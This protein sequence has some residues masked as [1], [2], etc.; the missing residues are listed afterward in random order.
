MKI[1]KQMGETLKLAVLTAIVVAAMPDL[2]MAAGSNDVNN[3][4]QNFSKNQ[5]AG[6]PVILNAA[7]YVGGL[8][9]MVTGAL[10]LKSHTVNPTS[11]K[12]AP[13]VAHL[14][15]GGGLTSLPALTSVIQTTVGASGSGATFSS[16]SNFMTN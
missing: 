16:F 2:A 11:E 12:L 15:I 4:V 3:L 14:A 1:S 10:K 5:L 9:M 8:F 13:A 7:C 6:L